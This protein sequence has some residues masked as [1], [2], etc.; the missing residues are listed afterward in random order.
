[1][2][3]LHHFTSWFNP[4][5]C[6]WILYVQSWFNLVICVSI[7]LFV[8]VHAQLCKNDCFIPNFFPMRFCKMEIFSLFCFIPTTIIFWGIFFFM[9]CHD[10]LLCF[11]LSRRR[12]QT[13]CIMLD[14]DLHMFKDSS[15]ICVRLFCLLCRFCV[16]IK[17][18]L[19]RTLCRF[20]VYIQLIL[21]MFNADCVKGSDLEGSS[22]FCPYKCS[23]FVDSL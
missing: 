11:L 21:T 23:W 3:E 13:V 16:H 1:M 5:I 9:V 19:L 12:L 10:A 14:A 22:F 17:I 18:Y 2:S 7:L 20:C 15:Y 6:L 8:F 4:V